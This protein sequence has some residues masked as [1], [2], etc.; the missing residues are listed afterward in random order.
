[1]KK[2]ILLL[3]FAQLGYAQ[4][5]LQWQNYSSGL[6]AG[7]NNT[8]FCYSSTF[9]SNFLLDNTTGQIYIE[10]GSPNWT[11]I[12]NQGFNGNIPQAIFTT[13]IGLF[14]ITNQS[15]NNN[16]LFDNFMMTWQLMPGLSH[17]NKVMSD[18]N[19][20]VSS[21]GTYTSFS[22][23]GYGNVTFI[24]SAFGVV[25]GIK[26]ISSNQAIC[27]LDNNVF[28]INSSGPSAN[29]LTSLPVQGN[30]FLDLEKIK[31]RLI[32]IGANSLHASDD[33]GL[34]WNSLNWNSSIEIT[35]ASAYDDILFVGTLS[36]GV[37][38]STDKGNSFIQINEFLPFNG[39]A[40]P[41]GFYNITSIESQN[42]NNVLYI[43][44]G[45]G[46]VYQL[47][48]ASLHGN[49]HFIGIP[50]G[51][52]K[53]SS[54]HPQ[55]DNS[56]GIV[57][58]S[59]NWQFPGAVPAS[60]TTLDP[61]EINFPNSGN[62]TI[63]LTVNTAGGPVVYTKNLIV[64]AA[65]NNN[66][67]SE[68]YNL[69]QNKLLSLSSA[70]SPEILPSINILNPNTANP[71]L[72]YTNPNWAS[73]TDFE[74]YLITE[75]TNCQI[76]EPFIVHQII[77]G[78]TIG[79]N[80]G[81]IILQCSN[82]IDSLFSIVTGNIPDYPAYGWWSTNDGVTFAD[83]SSYSTPITISPLEY[84]NQ[85]TWN[86][87]LGEGC[88]VSSNN[89]S[90]IVLNTPNQPQIVNIGNGI[91]QAIPSNEEGYRWRRNGVVI[92]GNTSASHLVTLPGYYTVQAL[93]YLNPPTQLNNCS[94]IES[95]IN[96]DYLIGVKGFCFLDNNNNAIYDAGDIPAPTLPVTTT[97]DTMSFICFTD[98]AGNFVNPSTIGANVTSTFHQ[99]YN[100]LPTSIT[101]NLDSI[102]TL[103]ADTF[104]LQ[105]ASMLN[106]FSVNL[107]PFTQPTLGNITQVLN[108]INHGNVALPATVSLVFPPTV[109]FV[110]STL[111]PDS[112]VANT[113]YFSIPIVNPLSTFQIAL[114][115]NVLVGFNSPGSVL[116][117][118]A[119][120]NPLPNET[121]LA[122]NS[123]NLAQTVL[124]AVDPNDKEM[125]G[126]HFFTTQ[127]LF[128]GE[129]FNYLIR[130]QNVGNYPA[131]NVVINDTLDTQLD[132]ST[133]EQVGSSHNNQLHVYNNQILKWYFNNIMLPDSASDLVGSQGYVAFK[134]KP[135]NNLQ[136][137]SIVK[138]KAAI[139][140]DINA[141]IITN[142][143]E[144]TIVAPTSIVSNLYESNFQVFPNPAN[145]Q[146]TIKSSAGKTLSITDI[147][148][149][150]V[151]QKQLKLN[152]EN[153]DISKF[154][155]GMYLV[156]V[157]NTTSKL[158]K[159]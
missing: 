134:I 142:E 87:T 77:A 56:S 84:N 35:C 5:A 98:T 132:F 156:N 53:Y 147:T 94:S 108:I 86:I 153:I 38:Y 122:N 4:N 64:N 97:V 2:L 150:I 70:N 72:Q 16:Y 28:L 50:Y 149:K 78:S 155:N 37:Y 22:F 130:F 110:S 79:S 48:S 36:N 47:N 118:N 11:T 54:I 126:G 43:T 10:N 135:H 120:L 125:L 102:T 115:F 51:I 75:N 55:F 25:G 42:M 144:T 131:T 88:A 112:I 83:S 8:N 154:T 26:R 146:I 68:E 113:L 116:Y 105:V 17:V 104:A 117:Y 39:T 62:H 123:F 73:Q 99:G 7:N 148:G 114:H 41:Y 138:N 45:N 19:F 129:Y 31:N 159:N 133:F 1:M 141:P 24:P 61:G 21:L 40:L 44:C 101:N 85:I 96:D 140:F 145:Q 27:L 14:A 6:T 95:A 3:L 13:S 18:S 59:Y 60:A 80:A 15:G 33:N 100:V 103:V 143:Y 106:D 136:I 12:S 119:Y 111:T 127:Q 20:V 9:Y 91:L 81:N 63:T 76:F 128:D 90:V 109:D 58:L 49:A 74:Y 158:I 71:T 124:A 66:Q 65:P 151:L 152:I 157:G 32:A 29:L 23:N 107:I 89:T 121:I 82:G 139:Y 137:G 34:T 69:C 57:P 30:V 93:N 92:T 46:N 52:C 67:L